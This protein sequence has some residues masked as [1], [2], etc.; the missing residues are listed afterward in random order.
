MIKEIIIE[1][2]ESYAKQKLKLHRGLNVIVGDTDTGKSGIVRAID[3]FSKNRPKGEPFR[4]EFL[5][6]K[7]NVKV[8][9]SFFGKD[10]LKINREKGK[11]VNRYTIDEAEY[12]ALRTDVPEEVKNISRINPVN[13]QGQHP[14]E[15]YFL[16]TDS[17]SQVAKKLNS[18]T[19]LSIMDKAQTECNSQVRSNNSKLKIYELEIEVTKKKLKELNWVD[20]AAISLKELEKDK[21]A[22]NLKQEQKDR[23][24]AHLSILN[25]LDFTPFVNLNKAKK[26]L[27]SLVSE[28]S[29]INTLTE[30][31]NRVLSLT[32][33]LHN[34]RIELD[35]YKDMSEAKKTLKTLENL[36]ERISN[37]EISVHKVSYLIKNILSIESDEHKNNAEINTLN[38][39]IKNHIETKGCPICKSTTY[40]KG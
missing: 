18:V 15:Q 2:F 40:R 12:K 33:Q 8:E 36:D 32:E 3:W 14:S 30:K 25:R 9:V 31:Q 35:A 38:K 1:G 6:D 10:K 7:E 24:Y 13:I 27:K 28:K 19:G 4:N 11:K 5:D 39:N 21:K 16:L 23:L 37:T 34:I 22:L 26:A 29:K 17:P 20:S